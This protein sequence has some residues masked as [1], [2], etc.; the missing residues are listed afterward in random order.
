MALQM[1]LGG[2]DYTAYMDFRSI[3]IQS[4][5]EAKGSTMTFRMRAYDDPLPPPK[6]GQEIIFL[7]GATREFAGTVL[8]VARRQGEGNRLVRYAVTCIDYTYLLDR[9]FVNAVYTSAAA[10]TMMG[11]VLDD[12]QSAA[13]AESANGDDHYDDFQGDKTQIVAGPVI[14]EQRFERLLPSQAFDVIAESSG[15]KWYVNYNKQ[16]VLVEVENDL[17]PLPNDAFGDALLDVDT[18]VTN[19]WDLE[20]E[21]SIE[22]IGTKPIIQDA[23]IKSTNTQAD[24]FIWRNENENKFELHLRPFSD[25]DVV[26][27]N[28]SVIG[29]LTIRLEHIYLQPETDPA[30][31]ECALYVGPRHAGGKAYVRLRPGDRTAN[32]T[33]I[34][35]YNYAYS[36]DHE[37]IDPE[38]VAEMADRTGGDGFHEFV[39]SRGS[40]IAAANLED[41]DE[42]SE[43]ILGRKRKVTRPGR[44]FSLT[45]GWDAG[46][47]FR[48]VWAK[49]S[50]D[51]KMW[52]ITVRKTVRTPADDPNI[53]DN[54][55]QSEIAYNNIPRA[56]RI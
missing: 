19:F 51:D 11:R 1:T 34:V 9:R 5:Q 14:R 27:V 13:N 48:R 17:A 12:L 49:E 15:M 16:I 20:E 41:L 38:G 54:V 3:K 45:K 28:H 44:F 53:G 32:D 56:M 18:D 31:G 10:G 30:T 47:V 43:I 39:F 26:T 36:D 24:R 6:A 35:T 37:N 22:G 2:T 25:L 46:E 4:S 55:I 8:R 33:I 42:I 23:L 21:E 7:D 29:N 40:E 52:V 50:L